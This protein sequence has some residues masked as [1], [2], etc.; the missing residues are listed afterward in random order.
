MESELTG[1]VTDLYQAAHM[2]RA[3]EEANKSAE[4]GD[5]GVGAVVVLE[6]QVVAVG[7]N[8]AASAQNPFAHAET[9][10]LTDFL[11]RKPQHLLKQA[12]LYSTFEP[13]PM[14]LGACLVVG[15]G[16]IVVGGT[17]AAEDQQWGGYQPEAFAELV[18]LSGPRIQLREGPYREECV[19][20][21]TESL[22]RTRQQR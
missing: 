9:Q 21:R 8:E 5:L 12:T 1:T 17:R 16:T 3:L 20:V 2:R 18:G 13:C 10:A 4:R 22:E 7:G 11:Q 19:L 15:L 6:G 14:C